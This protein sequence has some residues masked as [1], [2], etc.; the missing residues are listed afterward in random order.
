MDACRYRP[1]IKLNANNTTGALNVTSVQNALPLCTLAVSAVRGE[2]G[3]GSRC[4]AEIHKRSDVFSCLVGV[5]RH[6]RSSAHLVHHEH[7]LAPRKR[8]D[9]V[10][11]LS[12][13]RPA[14]RQLDGVWQRLAAAHDAR[15]LRELL[16]ELGCEALHDRE[17]PRGAAHKDDVGAAHL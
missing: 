2:R 9:A 11:H 15:A 10:P 8:R 13:A 5:S 17:L 4:P 7:L 3:R 6:K 14:A 1:R 12:E 16:G